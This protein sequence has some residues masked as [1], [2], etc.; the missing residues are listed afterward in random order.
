LAAAFEHLRRRAGDAEAILDA[1]Q[2]RRI[3]RDGLTR[4]VDRAAATLRRLPKGTRVAALQVPNS[5]GLIAAV[6]AAWREGLVPLAI[7]VE[8]KPLEVE[9]LCRRLGIAMRLAGTGLEQFA[10]EGVAEPVALPPGTAVLKLTSGSTGEPRAVAVT[11]EA[12][13]RGGAQIF[14]TMG[15]GP[16]DRNLVTLPIAHSY[17]FDNVLLALALQGTPLVLL[18]DR[19]PRRMLE[20]ARDARATVWPSV[21][22]LLDLVGRSASDGQVSSLRLVISAGAPLPP[23]VRELFA[24]RTGVRPRT[25]YGATECGGIAYDREGRG[26]LSDGCVGTPLDGVSIDLVDAQ[27]GVGRVR[28]RSPSVAAAALPAADS[29]LG[30]GTFLTADLGHLD[31]NGRLHLVGRAADF[32]KIGARKVHTAEVERVIRDVPGVRDV[33]VFPDARSSTSEALR[34]VV[35]ADPGVDRSQI[36]ARCESV[37]PDYKIPRWIELRDELPRTPRGKLDRGRL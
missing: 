2:G 34:A 18:S 19:L 6:L 14:S 8:R 26:D 36:L 37:L 15:I 1:D 4:L 20:V 5:P 31:A 33:V 32:V 7:E 11:G 16:L 28:V 9:G 17:A 13:E 35:V 30:D 21:P 29:E 25:F 3:S 24:V 27:D 22:V 10:I 12:L 23:A